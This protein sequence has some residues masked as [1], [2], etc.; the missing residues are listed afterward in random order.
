MIRLKQKS[1]LNIKKQGFYVIKPKIS[2]R[3]TKPTFI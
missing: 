1:N 3:S 2:S